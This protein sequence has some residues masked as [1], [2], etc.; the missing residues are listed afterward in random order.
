M[1]RKHVELECGATIWKSGMCAEYGVGKVV[2]NSFTEE[3]FPHCSET[4]VG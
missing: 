4:R 2:L 3:A 1:Q